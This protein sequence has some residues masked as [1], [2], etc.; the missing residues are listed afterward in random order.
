[1]K[2]N[3]SIKR[4]I[5][6]LNYMSMLVLVPLAIKMTFHIKTNL[7]IC[8]KITIK[9]SS[10]KGKNKILNRKSKKKENRIKYI[11]ILLHLWNKTLN[12]TVF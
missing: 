9:K 6:K 5:K 2:K 4:E 3:N 8:M 10:I 11:L 1:M 7:L 12:V